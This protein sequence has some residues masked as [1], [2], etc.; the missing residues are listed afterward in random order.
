[1]SKSKPL[2]RKL[3]LVGAGGVLAGSWWKSMQIEKSK[4]SRAERE[5]PDFVDEV[6]STVND[7]LNQLE[8]LD[9][10]GDEDD[11]R[12][13]LADYLTK[14]TD[15]EVEVAP[16]TEFGKPDILI[17][18]VLVLEVK[19][20]PGKAEMDRCIGQCANYSREW[21]TWIVLYDT[22]E[23]KINYLSHVLMDK[24]LNNIPII[25]FK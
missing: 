20:N 24:G 11:F 14:E 5:D 10:M 22:P 13:L 7:L 25:S 21:V 9:D 15:F 16:D 1:M 18:G 19:Y 17:E 6:C 2:I 4:R 3:I 23:S 12:D 8:I